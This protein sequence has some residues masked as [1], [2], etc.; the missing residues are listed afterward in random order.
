MSCGA[1]VPALFVKNPALILPPAP[2]NG[3][4]PAVERPRISGMKSSPS[5]TMRSTESA[6][7]TSAYCV[8]ATLVLVGGSIVILA[9]ISRKLLV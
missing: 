7:F 1:P 3:V 2:V 4:I 8:Y 9:L 6:T 5:A